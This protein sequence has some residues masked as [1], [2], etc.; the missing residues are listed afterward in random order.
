MRLEAVKQ[1]LG[2]RIA[3]E[4]LLGSQASVKRIVT[5][6]V[7]AT[8]ASILQIPDSPPRATGA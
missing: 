8:G 2:A 5:Y 1:G 4:L 6:Q 7:Y 3:A